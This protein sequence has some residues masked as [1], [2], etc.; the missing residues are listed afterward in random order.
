LLRNGADVNLCETEF[1]GRSPLHAAAAYGDLEIIDCVINAGASVNVLDSECVTSLFYAAAGGKSE[2][3]IYLLKNGA[4]VNPCQTEFKHRSPLH[5]AAA[6]D[7]REFMEILIKAGECVSV[8]DSDGA[9]P[10]FC[11]AAEGKTEAAIHLLENG[12]DVN[13]CGSEFKGRSPLHGA[14]QNGYLKI[15]DYLIKAGANVNIHD[16]DGATHLSCV[17]AKGT[18]EAVINLIENLGDV[19]L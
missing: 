17:F 4:D 6:Y 16:S 12:A 3:V 5:N 10:L 14:A 8:Q 9:T 11:A 13:L 19:S 7:D 15:M 2:A 1:N 18:T